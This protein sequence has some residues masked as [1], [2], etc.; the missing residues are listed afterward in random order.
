MVAQGRAFGRLT[1][2]LLILHSHLAQINISR[3]DLLIRGAKPC[4]VTQLFFI[5]RAGK[6]FEKPLLQ[7]L[8][9]LLFAQLIRNGPDNLIVGRPPAS[10]AAAVRK[11]QESGS[12]RVPLP[13]NDQAQ[14]RRPLESR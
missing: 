3:D 6:L 9:R 7:L 14:Q 12:H 11:Y 13:H 10:K 4:A 1:K 8:G 2:Q 5:V